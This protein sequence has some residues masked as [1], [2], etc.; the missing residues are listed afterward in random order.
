MVANLRL[1]CRGYAQRLMHAAEVVIH[2]VESEGMTVIVDF[3]RERVGEPGEAAHLHPHREVLALDVA[4][5]DVAESRPAVD[6]GWDRADA[7]RRAVAP[8]V[9]LRIVAVELDQHRVVDVG[10]ERERD[11][12]QVDA[13]AVRRQLHA[14]GQAVREVVHEVLGVPCVAV[15]DAPAHN[16]LSVGAQRGPRPHVAVAELPSQFL[17]HVLFLGVAER[18]DFVTLNLGAW[19]VAKRFALVVGAGL[20]DAG[21]QLR[22]GV[23]RN[24]CHADGRANRVSLNEAG[25]NRDLPFDWEIVHAIYYA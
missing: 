16:Q 2:E 3:L 10:A 9:A 4:G 5:R 23:L 6:D 15:A 21:K 24:A 7:G 20:A 25:E 8:A 1:H 12:F 14:V 18:P 11:G 19:Q 17:G 22:N 13:M